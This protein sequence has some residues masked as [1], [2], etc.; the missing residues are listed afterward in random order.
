MLLICV[1]IG[2]DWLI[3]H[4]PRIS[5]F[6]ANLGSFF[7]TWVPAWAFWALGEVDGWSCLTLC[8]RHACFV[9]ILTNFKKHCKTGK[10]D[11]LMTREEKKGSWPL[12]Q[13]IHFNFQ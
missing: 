11:S 7:K 10:Y 4:P 6:T 2:N 1:V 9:G 8:G 3:R 13:T 12:D 5:F